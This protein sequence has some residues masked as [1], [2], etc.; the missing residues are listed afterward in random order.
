[1]MY[2]VWQQT[3]AVYR[4]DQPRLHTRTSAQNASICGLGF[5]L[6]GAP[7]L[8]CWGG[9]RFGLTDQMNLSGV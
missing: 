7:C 1:M 8:A 3:M 4:V 2:S 9:V 6:E 5:G